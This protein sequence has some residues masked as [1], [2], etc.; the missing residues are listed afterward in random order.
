MR[1]AR[2]QSHVRSSAS[3]VPAAMLVA[4]QST[5]RTRAPMA[6][7]LMLSKR[8]KVRWDKFKFRE[9]WSKEAW[10]NQKGK[11]EKLSADE[12]YAIK[13]RLG[14]RAPPTR[15]RVPWLRFRERTEWSRQHPWNTEMQWNAY[16]GDDQAAI[17]E[18]L[19]GAMQ[20][21]MS[22]DG[23]ERAEM[24]ISG[25]LPLH[26]RPDHEERFT[27]SEEDSRLREQA[28]IRFEMELLGLP[29]RSR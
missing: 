7:G 5:K 26:A 16:T 22:N 8:R 6:E 25:L 10:R 14:A 11:W 29:P 15:R 24:E 4:P 28:E 3:A 1:R 12:Q 18:R 9:K 19:R 27:E 17:R 2:T 13:E 20:E 23:E 21:E